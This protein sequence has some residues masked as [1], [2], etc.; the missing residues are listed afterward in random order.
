MKISIYNEEN[1]SILIEYFHDIDGNIYLKLDPN[2]YF[3]YINAKDD[4]DLEKIENFD[5]LNNVNNNL[6]YSKIN[7]TNEKRSLRHKLL[8]KI[9]DDNEKL[10]EDDEY[11]SGD[12]DEEYKNM[13]KYDTEKKLYYVENE[14]MHN[15]DS[16]DISDNDEEYIFGKYGDTNIIKCLPKTLDSSSL[17][18]TIIVDQKTN[19][20][21]TSIESKDNNAYKLILNLNGTISLNM[22][23]SSKKT[24]ITKCKAGNLVCEMIGVANIN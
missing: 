23:G 20:I 3:L 18:D 14:K 10:K 11:A 1:Q 13:T 21:L 22:I 19:M 16:D 17:Y 4:I 6:K 8:E 24:Y 12:E 5:K 9:D 15:G 2:Y 7:N